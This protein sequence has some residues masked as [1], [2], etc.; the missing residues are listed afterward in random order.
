VA[1]AGAAV[2]ARRSISSPQ[3]EEGPEVALNASVNCSG[4]E[5]QVT[6]NDTAAWTDARVEIDSKYARVIPAVLAG[7]TI[8][9][10][11]TQLSDSNGNRFD[12]LSM[13]CES[14]DIQAFMRRGRGHF[15]SANLH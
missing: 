4:S 15:S 1:L 7:Q 9:I 13:K 6:N 8:T 10:T 12:P 5:V 14:A 3:T 11:G 2:I